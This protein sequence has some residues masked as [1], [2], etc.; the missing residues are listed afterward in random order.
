MEWRAGDT[1]RHREGP[2]LGSQRGTGALIGRMRSLVTPAS[3]CLF[4]E[5]KPD[6]VCLGHRWPGT[7]RDRSP[8]SSSQHIPALRCSPPPDSPQTFRIKVCFTNGLMLLVLGEC[9]RVFVLRGIERLR[10]RSRYSGT[11]LRSLEGIDN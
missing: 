6:Q 3:A 4:S 7:L 2:E 1:E 10:E 11:G 8:I 5:E 9:R